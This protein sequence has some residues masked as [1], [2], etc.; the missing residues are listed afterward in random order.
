MVEYKLHWESGVSED[1]RETIERDKMV[2]DSLAANLKEERA[3]HSAAKLVM[4]L[5]FVF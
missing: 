4:C 3:Q 1:L 5:I 2:A